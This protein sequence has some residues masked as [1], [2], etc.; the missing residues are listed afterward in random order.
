L[1]ATLT[2]SVTSQPLAGETISFSL[3][4]KSVGT[5]VTNSSGVASLSGVATTDGAGT[6]SGGVVATFAGS[7]DYISSTATGNLVVAAHAATLSGVTGNA[8]FGGTATL[9][10]TLNNN[11]TDAAISG[12]TISFTLDGK[13][14]GTAVTNSSGVATLAGITTTDAVGTDTNGVV[15]TYAGSSTYTSSTATGDLNVIQAQTTLATVGGTASFGGTATLSATLTSDV[16][17][18]PLSGQT[19]SFTLDGISVGSASTNSSGV[20]TVF[21]VA[22]S[23]AVGTD[24]NVVVAKFAGSTDYASTTTTGNLVV[25]AVGTSLGSVSGTASFGGSASLTATLTNS[26]TH[27][28]IVGKT[29]AFSLDN[30][31]VGSAV[32]NSS[33]VATLTDIAANDGVGTDTGG[34]TAKFIGDSTDAA[35][36]GSGNLVVSPAATNLTEIS[37]SAVSGGLA[38]LT[39]TLL[40]SVTGLP[41]ANVP[42]SFKLDG[43]DAGTDVTSSSGVATSNDVTTTDAVGTDTG[44]VTVAFA[45][46]TDYA[47]SDG[48]GDLI[49]SPPLT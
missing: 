7:T 18:Q 11:S 27:V 16:T 31:L 9:S 17:S 38:T 33:G 26:T 28:G 40:S 23:D 24:T 36:N 20:A 34:V 22:T 30:A 3:D 32:T 21:N 42:V 14:V 4:G 12:E 6:D 29:I 25:S 10:A 35:S 13:S 43:V 1:N 45:G 46:N 5:A 39:A 8:T 41:I 2:S 48:T 44:G 37:G 49:V 47:S 19:V 15:A